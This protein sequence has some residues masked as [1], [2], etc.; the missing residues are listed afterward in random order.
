MAVSRGLVH[1]R[2]SFEVFKESRERLQTQGLHSMTPPIRREP[3]NSDKADAIRMF[4]EHADD[5]N[6]A[7][8]IA[9]QVV[10]GTLL[11]ADDELLSNNSTPGMTSACPSLLYL[12]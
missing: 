2:S 12:P 6:D 1:R 8:H 4:R 7:F 5:T 10:A 9:A 11:R 3:P